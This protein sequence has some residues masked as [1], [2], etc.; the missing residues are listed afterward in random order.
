MS[1]RL[2]PDNYT[3]YFLGRE[4]VVE[5]VAVE[6]HTVVGPVTDN[7]KRFQP[8][9]WYGLLGQS[10]FRQNSL[11]LVKTASSIEAISTAFNPSA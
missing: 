3:T 1:A 7:L 10:L 11:Q 4:A 5:A 8:V 2:T 9:G 6:P